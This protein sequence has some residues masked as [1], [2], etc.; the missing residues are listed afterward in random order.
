LNTPTTH[1][2]AIS[3][4]D[5]FPA[6]NINVNWKRARTK[7]KHPVHSQ[8]PPNCCPSS[9]ARR[10]YTPSH[11]TPD[12]VH[13]RKAPIAIVFGHVKSFTRADIVEYF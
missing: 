5:A 9:A 2:I 12:M 1:P 7:G 3:V 13:K 10:S 11:S 8:L 6:S 4:F